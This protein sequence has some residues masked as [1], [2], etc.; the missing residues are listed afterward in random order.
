MRRTCFVPLTNRMHDLPVDEFQVCLLV[1][2]VDPDLVVQPLAELVDPHDGQVGVG[3]FLGEPD[4]RV[5]LPWDLL[6]WERH[7]VCHHGEK[8]LGAEVDHGSVVILNG[9]RRWFGGG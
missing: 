4:Q 5:N 1:R 8:H 7:V 2:L 3:V 6:P 9:C